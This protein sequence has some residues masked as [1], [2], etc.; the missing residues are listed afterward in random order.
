MSCVKQKTHKTPYRMANPTILGSII[1][2]PA[3]ETTDHAIRMLVRVLHLRIVAPVTGEH[4]RA[5]T[6]AEPAM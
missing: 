5:A 1:L 6:E 2:L 3:T 4:L